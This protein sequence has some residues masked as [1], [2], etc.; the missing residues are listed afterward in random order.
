M[1][2]SRTRL[3]A[4]SNT[5]LPNGLARDPLL[6]T[7]GLD[8]Q[9]THCVAGQQLVLHA[10]GLPVATNSLRLC[11][12]RVSHIGIRPIG[13]TLSGVCETS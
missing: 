10:E 2:A 7:L 6:I 13:R 4:S 8:Q 9:L 3:R 1:V 5:S 12:G 11:E